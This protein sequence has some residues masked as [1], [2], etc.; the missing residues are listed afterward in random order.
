MGRKNIKKYLMLFGIGNLL[1][2]VSLSGCEELEE[3]L[4]PAE[5]VQNYILVTVNVEACVIEDAS[6]T[7]VPNHQVTIRMIKDSGETERF[8]PITTSE[9]CA[10]ATAPFKVYKEQPVVVEAYPDY[11]PEYEQKKTLPWEVTSSNSVNKAYTWNVY[12]AFVI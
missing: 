4:G 11:F 3:L 2:L 12:F 6:Q 10:Y 8:F 5:E 7:P 9:G 1:L